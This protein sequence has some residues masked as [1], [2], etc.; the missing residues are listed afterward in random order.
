[1]A[2]D[3]D[4][5]HYQSPPHVR[6]S[7]SNI[8]EAAP[9]V[10]VP[11]TW[12]FFGPLLERAGRRGFFAMGILPRAA[13]GYPEAE[14][15]R[16]LG[17]FHGRCAL[18]ANVVRKMMCAIPGV[19]GDDVERD[20]LGYVSEGGFDDPY[21]WRAP[22]IAFKFPRAIAGLRTRSARLRNQSQGWWE[23]SVGPAGPR[24]GLDALVLFRAAVQH[25]D[26]CLYLHGINRMLVQ[27]PTA[28]LIEL[29]EGAG[30]PHYAGAL[31]S[32]TSGIDEGVVADALYDVAGGRSSLAALVAEHGFH[33]PNSGDVSNRS[34]REDPTPLERLMGSLREAER[35]A[36]R[37]ARAQAQA[38]Q[39]VGSLL[40]SLG[41]AERLRARTLMR[42]AAYSA[43][44]LELTKNSFLIAVDVAR[45]AARA[46]GDELVATGKLRE[47]E[48]V[49]MFLPHELIEARGRDL[50][51]LAA[52]RRDQRDDHLAVEIPDVWEG[53]PIATPKQTGP[54]PGAPDIVRGRGVSPGV[55][56]GRVCVVMDT[57]EA[58]PIELGDVLVSPTTDPSWVALMTVAS[59]LV[60]DIGTAA[61][62]GA[63]VAR[64]LGVPCVIGTTT[65]TKEL[66]HGDRVRVDGSAGLVEVVERGR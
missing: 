19:S 24:P 37:R 51:E 34:W 35:P 21:P 12:G 22:A 14:G 63:I 3:E 56:E 66:R 41:G 5:L 44:N 18:N 9:G 61:S 50:R 20:V 48:D 11:M 36:E 10:L 33:G 26:R 42:L 16:M 13:A 62:H 58:P 8:A 65:G 32:G 23:A 17:A 29:A 55:A 45:A 15:D 2:P 59:A 47:R 25:F 28:Q 31:L 54:A 38:A 60:I 49:F 46:C 64:E 57:A 53:N 30:A 40:E 43:R 6:W 4:P 1:M 27:A 52:E 39:G 7:R